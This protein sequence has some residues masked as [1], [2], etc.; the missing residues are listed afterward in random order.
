[1]ERT[2]CQLSTRFTDGLSSNDAH[3]VSFFGNA[4][5]RQVFT[6]TFGTN[7]TLGFAGQNRTNGYR[8]YPNFFDEFGT[9]RIDVISCSEDQFIGDWIDDIVQ[10][11]AAFDTRYE[12]FDYF[13]VVF[14][15]S[16]FQPAQGATVFFEDDHILSNVHQTTSQV[17]CVGCFK[18][19]IR[20]TFT[21]TVR[22]DEVFQNRQAVHKVGQDGVFD[23]GTTG[24]T[25]FP[26]FGHQAPQTA[27]LLD[28]LLGTP[29]TRVEHHEYGVEALLV[30]GQLF[31]ERIGDAVVRICPTV[32]D[33]V[34]SFVVGD[35]TH[36][37]VVP[38]F[39]HFAL[40]F[41]QRILLNGRNNQVSQVE[42]QPT[43]ESPGKAHFLDF[44][45][46][47]GSNC[48]IRQFDYLADYGFEVFLGHQAVLVRNTFRHYLVEQDPTHRS[49]DQTHDFLSVF[50]NRNTYFDLGV[51]INF[52]FV[53]GND[54]LF[55]RVKFHAFP[56]HDHI[57]NGSLLLGD[58]VQ[59]QYH[60]LRRQGDRS[61]VLRVEHVVRCQHQHLGFQNGCLAQRHVNG[62]LVTVKVGVER[63]TY[64]RV[65][66]N[67]LTFYQTWLE[68]LNR[69]TVQRW[70]PVEENRVSLEDIFEDFPDYRILAVYEFF[71]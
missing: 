12:R 51:Q 45:Q 35:Q 13:V 20:Q 2:Q 17:T 67:R 11:I 54:Y 16:C 6:I 56:F 26:W 9:L 49:I 66:L 40:S 38:H 42:G 24:V 30:A 1:M 15:G 29:R 50:R 53:E 58:V 44:V 37:V 65:Q 34:V 55:R 31:H 60:V 39:V 43:P 27:Q 47:V 68:C 5:N 62:H 57:S 22:R 33:L 28:L 52:T 18:G 23:N 46:E 10:S 32:D 7:P 3:C 63:A 61:T 21:R 41:F 19:S 64:Q 8:F 69:Q 14:Q 25:R 71:G 36:V 70:S 4:T 59:A 48:K